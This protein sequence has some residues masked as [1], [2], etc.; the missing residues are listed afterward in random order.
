MK[1][2][3]PFV[4]VPLSHRIKHKLLAVREY[5]GVALACHVEGT[6]LS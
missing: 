6:E 1:K 3:G 5:H 4:S 2:D